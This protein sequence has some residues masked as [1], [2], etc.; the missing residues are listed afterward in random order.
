VLAARAA[1]VA[2]APLNGIAVL[3]AGNAGQRFMASDRW[4]WRFEF[5]VVK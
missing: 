4:N 5:V 3:K 1:I 2:D